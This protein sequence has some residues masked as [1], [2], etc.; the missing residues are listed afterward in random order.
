MPPETRSNDVN[1]ESALGQMLQGDPVLRGLQR[2]KNPGLSLGILV[3]LLGLVH[4]LLLPVLY[5]HWRTSGGVLGALDDWPYLVIMMGIVP[6]LAVY[7][8]RQPRAIHAVFEGVAQRIGQSTAAAEFAADAARPLGWRGWL[9]AAVLVASVQVV[10]FVLDL[11]RI[12]TPIW[13]T[14][15]AVMIA[16]AQPLRFA[17]FYCLLLILVRQVLTL[18]G[19]NRFFARFAVE[20]A[21]LHPDRAG[22][23]R[24][25]GDYVLSGALLLALVGLTFGMT[26]MRGQSNPE[27]LTPEFYAELVVYLA[28]IPV[29]FLLPL[30]TAHLRM[31]TAKEKLLMEV[32]EQ[33]DQEYRTLLGNLRKN[34][35]NLEDVSR[36]EAVQ[37]VYQ[38]AAGSPEWP[39]NAEILSKFGAAV[40]LPIFAPLG[41]DLLVNF[42]GR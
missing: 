24:V 29:I 28:A 14:V 13:L 41:V 4:G 30:W 33:F 6:L 39:F 32:A 1:L 12:T 37:K 3:A 27:V 18:I 26:L 7:Y 23:L 8:A 40:L 22:G 2:W 17:A 25:V 5:G 19:L 31:Q 11:Q 38:I 35:L 20:I 42:V 16:S 15:N 36:V 21:P 9:W 34:K 10:L